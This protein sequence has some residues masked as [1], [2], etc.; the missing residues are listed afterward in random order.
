[1]LLFALPLMLPLLP[2]PSQPFMAVL[3]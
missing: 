3:E 1:M 2:F